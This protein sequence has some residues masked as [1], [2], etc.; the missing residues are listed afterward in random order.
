[1]KQVI[2]L[3]DAAYRQGRR[4]VT[5]PFKRP[6]NCRFCSEPLS[7]Y[8]YTLWRNANCVEYNE[9]GF[10]ICN[11]CTLFLE[12]WRGV[13]ISIV[14]ETEWGQ[15]ELL[16]NPDKIIQDLEREANNAKM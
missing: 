13:L 5:D 1:M 7:K 4:I 3:K 2:T 8:G 12:H 6:K 9:P 14:P 16:P 11:L 15:V 10:P